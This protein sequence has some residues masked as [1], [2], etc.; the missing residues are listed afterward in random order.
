[1]TAKIKLNA[2]SGGGSISIQAPSSS[3]N[4]RVHFLPDV[5][6][7]TVLT[8]TSSD[9]DRYKAGEVVQVV[10]G[11]F[12]NLYSGTTFAD[13]TST[14]YVNYGDMKLTITPKFSNSKLIFETH[15]NSKI[16][17]NDGNTQFEL[18]DT[19][20]S[21]SLMT[22]GVSTHYYA[23]TDAYQNNQ[24]RM[25]GDAGYTTSI[26]IQVRVRVVQGGTLNSDYA[27]QPRLMTLTEVKQ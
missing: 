21:R 27:D 25:F 17:D 11:T 24:I 8:T 10:M 14:S 13:I 9:A 7:G 5:A 18:Y 12:Q 20:N 16:N 22:A 26:V 6:D 1:M 3:S 19:T 15:I 4:N 23:P 2:A